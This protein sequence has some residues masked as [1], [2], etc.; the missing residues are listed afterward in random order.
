[1]R[2]T[3]EIEERRIL[4]SMPLVIAAVGCGPDG[5]TSLEAGVDETDG[6]EEGS[7]GG[8]RDAGPQLTG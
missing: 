6:D 8:R 1:M 4:W 2:A 7:G 5:P 3:K